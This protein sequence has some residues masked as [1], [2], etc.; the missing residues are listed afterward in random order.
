MGWT[1]SPYGFV[2]LAG[3]P[4]VG[5]IV[6]AFLFT[7]NINSPR[8]EIAL[9]FLKQCCVVSYT[10]PVSVN[11][12]S[13]LYLGSLIDVYMSVCVINSCRHIHAY[14]YIF[15]HIYVYMPMFIMHIYVCM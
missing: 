10:V 3:P 15:E 12:H 14:M 5:L 9:C 11:P 1:E 8:S 6:A 4:L 7:M 13:R 2:T